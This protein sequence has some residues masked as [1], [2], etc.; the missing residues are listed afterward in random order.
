MLSIKSECLN[1]LMILGERHLRRA[2]A[3]YVEHY[4]RERAHLGLGDRLI[5]GVPEREAGL[6]VRRKHFDGLLNHYHS[7][8]GMIARSIDGTQRGVSRGGRRNGTVQVTMQGARGYS[9][10]EGGP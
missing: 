6:V 5:E 1:R 4:H 10:T 9:V 8:S 3:E 7:R 2:I